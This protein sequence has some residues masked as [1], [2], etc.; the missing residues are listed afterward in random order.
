MEERY[1]RL[2]EGLIGGGV[3]WRSGGIGGRVGW[4]KEQDWRKGRIRERGRSG[5]G[6]KQYNVNMKQIKCLSSKSFTV[7]NIEFCSVIYGLF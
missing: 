6:L 2:E 3:D 7:S 4:R 5:V 1:C